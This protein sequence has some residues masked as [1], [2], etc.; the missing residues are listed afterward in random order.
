METYEPVDRVRQIGTI[1][2]IALSA[3]IYG[4]ALGPL[5]YHYFN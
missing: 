5:V 4:L 2:G 3:V 1:I